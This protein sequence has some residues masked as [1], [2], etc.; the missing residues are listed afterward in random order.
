MWTSVSHGL[1]LPATEPTRA[2]RH[3]VPQIIFNHD[4]ERYAVIWITPAASKRARRDEFE[5]MDKGMT[6]APRPSHFDG[7]LPPRS[8]AN[9][10]QAIAHSVERPGN[11]SSNEEFAELERLLGH[12]GE[13]GDV[14]RLSPART[15]QCPCPT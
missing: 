13:L 10:P 5:P 3:K 2:V 9:P 15:A 6:K 14:D 4:L 8:R 11:G 12:D 1:C 7:N